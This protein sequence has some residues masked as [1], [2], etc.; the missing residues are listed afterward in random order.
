MIEQKENALFFAYTDSPLG[1]L[2]LCANDRTLLQLMFTKTDKRQL[3]KKEA[4]ENAILKEAKKQLTNYF[5]GARRHFDLPLAPEGTE[6]QLKVWNELQKIPFGKTITY[7]E[8]AKKLG[9]ANSIRA[10][11]SAN[12]KNPIA[13]IIPCHRVVGSDNS[14]TGYSGDLWRKQWLLEHEEKVIGSVLKLF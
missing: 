5:E 7:L 14:L 4:R 2:E 11:A 3:P 9:D 13:I 6:F 1:E 12:G 10:A 8:L